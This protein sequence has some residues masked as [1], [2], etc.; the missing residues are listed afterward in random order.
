MPVD[1]A[2]T[3][4]PLCASRTQVVAGQ[5]PSP[6][7][8][9]IVGEA[10]GEREDIEGRPF[11]GRSGAILD[12][13]LEAA[14]V[15]R[16]DVMITNVVKCRPPGN[17]KPTREEVEACRPFLEWEIGQAAAPVIVALGATAAKA[18]LGRAV[19]VSQTKSGTDRSDIAGASREVFVTLHPASSR[20]RKG[21][22]EQ[23]ASAL[24]EAAAK[25]GLPMRKGP[26]Q[27]Q[28]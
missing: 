21:A 22:R 28:L 1:R 2:C 19:K 5:G 3:R 7:L 14:G 24:G 11:V 20:F 27:G 13:A 18:V 16:A 4:C 15:A 17:R 10:P 8:L 23:I 9:V 26:A 12:G 6:S 25:A